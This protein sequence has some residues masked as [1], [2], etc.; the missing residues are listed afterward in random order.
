M[1]IAVIGSGIAGLGAAW[2]LQ[3]HHDITVFEAE[4]R[5]GGHANTVEADVG[6]A[7]IPV[8]T[9]FIV[10]ND[11]NYPNLIQLF[12][13]LGVATEPSDMSFSVSV[14][15]TF[16]YAGSLGGLLADPRNVVRPRMWRLLRDLLRFYEAAPAILEE[17][18]DLD[19][20]LGEYLE[21][22]GYSEAFIADHLLPMGAA[23]WSS[24]TDDMLTFPAVSFVRFFQNHGLLRLK[25]R[26]NWRTVTGGSRAYV[27]LLIRPFAHRIRT[28]CPVHGVRRRGNRVIVDFDG[29]SEPFDQVVIATHGDQ[30]LGLLGADAFPEERAVLSAF[31]YQTNRAILHSDPRL[32]PRRRGTWSS[33]N[34]MVA[35]DAGNRPPAVTYWMNR[36]QNIDP[37]TPLFVSLNP[38]EVPAAH[39]TH[40]MF[41]YDHPIF[42]AAA[43][44][45]QVALARLQG[46]NRTWFC[47]SYHGYGFHEDAFLS[48]CRVAAGLA[49]APDWWSAPSRDPV[50]LPMA[51]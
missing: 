10:Y 37:T 5:V 45:A 14:G 17:P 8:D 47:G 32:M 43:I 39:L 33:W 31:K 16:E 22:E 18:T 6:G 19:Q 1:K 26:P 29:G 40:G 42:S 36:L 2:L 27:E 23:I 24:S 48:G 35:N 44:K 3:R 4:G 28:A 41:N 51:A 30:A 13:R 21:Q 38:H 34:Y 15:G 9:G 50:Q 20:T 25:D 11:V 7:R 49:A 46:Q 12:D